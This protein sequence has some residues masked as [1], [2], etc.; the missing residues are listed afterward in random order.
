MV[1]ASRVGTMVVVVVE[2]SFEF[3]SA[4]G[5]GGVAACV[6]PAVGQ[7]AVEAFDLAVGL[8]PIWPGALVLDPEL[9]AGV[10]P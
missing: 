7:G 8:R 2:P 10:A 9:G 3:A 6:G 5:F 4:F 1:P